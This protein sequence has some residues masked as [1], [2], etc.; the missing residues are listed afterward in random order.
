MRDY[1][2]AEVIGE[3]LVA[4]GGSLDQNKT[5]MF[6]NAL[7]LRGNTAK[8][9][10]YAALAYGRVD[11]GNKA[12]CNRNVNRCADL[13]QLLSKL[14]SSYRRKFAAEDAQ[15]KARAEAAARQARAA[16]AEQAREAAAVALDISGSGIHS[17]ETFTV[18]NEWELDWSYDC[19]DFGSEDGNGTGNFIVSIQGDASDLPGVNQLGTSDSGTEY[20]HHGGTVY[21]EINSECKW[22]VKA[23]NE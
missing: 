8:A 18:N 6:A 9:L 7:Y 2:A 21:L 14:D 16:A 11:T 10:H 19:S 12:T 5:Y 15:A 3:A 17:T 20:Y 13:R 1:R 4:G 23:V 22:A